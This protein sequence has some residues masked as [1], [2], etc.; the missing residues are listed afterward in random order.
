MADQ[1][2]IINVVASIKPSPLRLVAAVMG[3]IG[4]PHLLLDAPHRHITS[5]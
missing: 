2:P 5:P 3:D 1:K 4:T